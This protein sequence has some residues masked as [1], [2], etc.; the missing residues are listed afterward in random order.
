MPIAVRLIRAEIVLVCRGE[1]VLANLIRRM[2]VDCPGNDGLELRVRLIGIPKGIIPRLVGWEISTWCQRC[3]VA[4][5]SGP[6]VKRRASVV[7]D[8]TAVQ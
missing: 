8:A 1:W 2:V 5:D 3:V 4:D 6:N 7:E